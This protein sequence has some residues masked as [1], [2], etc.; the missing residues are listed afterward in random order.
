MRAKR[1]LVHCISNIVTA[2]DCANILYAAGA[3]PM[4]AEA[5][6]EMAEIS[7]LADAAVLNLGTPSRAKYAAARICL[8]ESNR[9]GKPVVL[10]PV[11]VGASSWRLEN[12]A[13]LLAAGSPDIL[14][15]NLAEAEALLGL[16]RA[17]QG[18]DSPGDDSARAAA[19]G[20]GR[21]AGSLGCA[22]L[23]TGETDIVATAAAPP[24]S[25][26][27]QRARPARHRQRLYAQ[28]ALRRLRRRDG[29]HVRRRAHRRRFW[30]LLRRSPSALLRAR[31]GLLPRRAH[32]RRRRSDSSGSRAGARIG[33]R[34]AR[35]LPPSGAGFAGAPE[36]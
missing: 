17:E 6:E 11:G 8:E 29:R 23:L 25:R 31:A 13:R 33:R 27:R 20:R 15:V 1:P 9:L 7:A 16:R 10:D 5:R 14:R 18:V 34:L 19:P 2:N 36:R 24:P 35:W 30:K 32:G 3:S 21:L 26:G 4:M 28:R 22:V 12:A